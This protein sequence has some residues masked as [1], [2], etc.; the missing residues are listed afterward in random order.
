MRDVWIPQTMVERNPEMKLDNRTLLASTGK[1]PVEIERLFLSTR[2]L[3][4]DDTGHAVGESSLGM[5]DEQYY[6][7]TQ[8][9]R[10]RCSTCRP[11]EFRRCRRE[12]GF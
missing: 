3:E 11:G 9:G 12:H 10:V 1:R 2:T 5:L 6:L 7:R 8:P 4:H